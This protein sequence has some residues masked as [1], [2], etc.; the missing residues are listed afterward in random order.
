MQLSVADSLR[1]QRLCKALQPLVAVHGPE[2]VVLA[3]LSQWMAAVAPQLTSPPAPLLEDD[4]SLQAFLAWLDGADVL[5]GAFWIS[6]AYAQ[7]V[8]KTHRKHQAMYFT[9]PHLAKRLLDHAGDSLL[10]GPIIDPACGGAAFLAPVALRLAEQLEGQ[11]QTSTEI[12]TYIER[13]L[14]GVDL[15]PFLCLLSKTFLR[16]VLSR[17][18]ITA[19]DEPNFQVT[20]GDGLGQAPLGTGGYSLV[21]CNPP[22]RKMTRAE[23]VPYVDD[24]GPLMQGQPN[25]YTLFIAR[26]MA[27]LRETGTAVLLTP[28]SF[29]SGKSFAALR[30]HMIRAGHIR[31]IDLIHDKLG[32]FLGAQQDTAITLWQKQPA[33][34]RGTDIHVL[35]AE[36]NWAWTGQPHLPC[37]DQPWPL[38]REAGD[39][40]LLQLFEQRKHSLASYGYVLRTGFIVMHR[41]QLPTHAKR[42]DAHHPGH[43]MPLIWQSDICVNK[44]LSLAEATWVNHRYIDIGQ[45]DA[46]GTIRRP[47]VVIQRVTSAEQPR[48]LVCAPVPESAYREFGGVVGENHVSFIEQAGDTAL[49]DTEL[50]CAILRTQTVDRLFRCISGVTNVSAYELAALPMPDPVLVKQA[51]AAGQG[52]ENAVRIGFGLSPTSFPHAQHELQTCDG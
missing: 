44:P 8:D 46:A 13:N 39:A 49:T 1:F 31:Q 21:L 24:Y 32:I 17:H 37:N 29:V 12:L 47:A 43:L 3:L 45:D 51:V 18:I 2:N 27:L 30:Q 26:A 25:L 10:N 5:T 7:L 15:D 11:G 48:R 19:R 14:H 22:Y 4:A 23:T 35:G 16:I 36:G 50:L 6:S 52:M 33:E 42:T 20:V 9:S 41:N 38:P 34:A 40:T 28:M